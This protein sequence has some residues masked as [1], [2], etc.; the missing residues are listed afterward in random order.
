[1]HEES[2]PQACFH[3]AVAERAAEKERT[4]Q[5]RIDPLIGTGQS[6]ARYGDCVVNENGRTSQV[7]HRT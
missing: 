5:E 2:I 7:P 3:Y 6:L 1:M 4:L